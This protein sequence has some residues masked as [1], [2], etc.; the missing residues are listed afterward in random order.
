MSKSIKAFVFDVY[1][2]LFDVHSVKEVAVTLYPGRGE[3]IS[4]TWRKKQVEYSLLRQLMG[5]YRSFLEK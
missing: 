2:T 3:S 1:G 5:T 4:Q